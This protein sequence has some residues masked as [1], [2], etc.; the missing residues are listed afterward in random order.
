MRMA[1]VR[2][3]TQ[4]RLFMIF[5]KSNVEMRLARVRALTHRL[6]RRIATSTLRRN[7]VGPS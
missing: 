1:R 2:A 7:E 4:D 3:L 5:V 6:I